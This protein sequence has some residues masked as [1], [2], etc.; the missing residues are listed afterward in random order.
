[1]E[2]LNKNSSPSSDCEIVNSRIINAPREIVFKA[3]RDPAHLKNWWG[4]KG[5]TNTFKE[6]DFQPNG[7]WSFVMHGP[8]KKG[9]YTNKCVFVKILKPELIIWDRITNPKFQVVVTF[10]DLKNDTTR[11]TFKMVF[12]S[13]EACN[14]LRSFAPDKNEENLDKLEAEIKLMSNHKP[15]PE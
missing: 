14:K 2:A 1:M 11:V 9:N 12:D 8:D 6:F 3:W 13:P 10:E 7:K 15:E 5:F 4:P